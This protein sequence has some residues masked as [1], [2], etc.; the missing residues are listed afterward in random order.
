[1]L[2]RQSQEGPWA[3]LIS[4]PDLLR[5]YQTTARSCLSSPTESEWYL[6]TNTRIVFWLPH[7][8]A[9]KYTHTYRGWGSTSNPKG[10]NGHWWSHLE[11]SGCFCVCILGLTSGLCHSEKYGW[12]VGAMYL[13]SR[14]SLL[15]S[16]HFPLIFWV[17][18][19]PWELTLL[20]GE[21]SVGYVSRSLQ[22]C[23]QNTDVTCIGASEHL[24]SPDF[25]NGLNSKAMS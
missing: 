12:V 9:H 22:V 16:S 1:M 11:Q 5:K 15:S 21:K 2:R 20:E 13:I 3:S 4:Q 18:L 19:G 10:S 25:M 17:L 14:P 7:T 6:R 24:C 8:L 23:T